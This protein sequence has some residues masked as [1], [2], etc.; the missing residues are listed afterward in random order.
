[1]KKGGIGL[2]RLQIVHAKLAWNSSDKGYN[3]VG[4]EKSWIRRLPHLTWLVKSKIQFKIHLKA[5]TLFVSSVCLILFEPLR[6]IK[7]FT[8]YWVSGNKLQLLVP[9]SSAPTLH[10]RGNIFYEVT[11][12]NRSLDQLYRTT[13]LLLH[14]SQFC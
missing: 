9:D 4:A 8:I 6:W 12:K 13:Y 10:C 1:M 7:R 11:I 5:I 14:F 3:V 2:D